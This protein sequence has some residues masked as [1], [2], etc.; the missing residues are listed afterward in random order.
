MTQQTKP[1][2]QTTEQ[3]PAPSHSANLEWLE[4]QIKASIPVQG[5]PAEVYLREH[6]RIA[7]PYPDSLRYADQYQAKPN[8]N[9]RSCILAVARDYKGAIVAIQSLEIDPDSGEKAAKADKPQRYTVG[10]I[11]ARYQYVL[12]R[13][14]AQ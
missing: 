9:K 8:G 5:S 6:R 10:K 13:V 7:A 2:P 12:D 14:H 11:F 4:Q 1:A 3:K